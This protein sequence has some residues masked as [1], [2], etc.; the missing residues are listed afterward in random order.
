[1]DRNWIER[2]PYPQDWE[3]W[4]SKDSSKKN[5]KQIAHAIGADWVIY[6]DL[7]DLEACVTQE[8]SNLTRFDSSCFNGIYVTGDVNEEYFASL[9]AE[10]NDAAME[11]K[12]KPRSFY[13]TFSGE[14]EDTSTTIDMFNDWL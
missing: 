14:I 13:R 10:R 12:N 4:K 2:I 1:M 5:E 8:N 11:L 6:Q 7:H 3:S 9:Q